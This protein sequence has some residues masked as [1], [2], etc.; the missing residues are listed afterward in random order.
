MLLLS[1]RSSSGAGIALFASSIVVLGAA[2]F[3]W[4]ARSQSASESS[5]LEGE[6]L[7][8]GSQSSTRFPPEKLPPSDSEAVMGLLRRSY[9]ADNNLSYS[10]DVQTIAMYGSQKMETKAHL[11][12]APRRLTVFYVSGDRRGLEGGYNERWFWRRESKT[13]PMKAYASV[14]YRPEEMAAQR[15]EQLILNYDGAAGREESVAGRLCDVV[16]VRRKQA[17]PDTQG[18]S[19]RLWLD[20][21]TAITVRTDSFNYQGK[22]VQ[23]STLTNLQLQPKVSPGTFVPPQAMFA[24][25]QKSSW[26]T[27]QLGNDH[28]KVAN[29]TGLYPPKPSWLPA[30][31]T[32]DSVG[33]QHASL[34]KGVPLAALSRYGDGLNII[35]IFAFKAPTRQ[36]AAKTSSESD[37]S[38]CTFGAG[39]MAMRQMPNGVTLL[40]IADLPTPMLKRVL[41]N[42]RLR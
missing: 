11:V 31:F 12:R 37:N 13:A 35:T 40:A 14:A 16:E 34:E 36:T 42:T 25:A 17:L 7:V 26:N 41:D 9:Q 15:F 30:G 3:L 23:R 5:S 29:M 32:F 4:E 24:M 28:A 10:A 6:T 38:S 2:F 1:P 18:P 39:A 27:E 22:L 20:R 33:M 21:E 8:A 19:K